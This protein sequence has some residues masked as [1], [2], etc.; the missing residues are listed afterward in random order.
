MPTNTTPEQLRR[1]A[2]QLRDL[3]ARI[4]KVPTA[5]LV[6][7][8]GTETWMGPSAQLCADEVRRLDTALQQ[9]RTD[10]LSTAKAF[11][12]QAD[13]LQAAAALPAPP[14]GVS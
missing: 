6:V 14:K 11:E 5:D 10:L 13:E 12:R 7:L 2:G 3:A 9:D 1:R 4:K 8:A